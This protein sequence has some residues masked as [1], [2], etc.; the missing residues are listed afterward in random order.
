M[1]VPVAAVGNR[2][3]GF[4]R[5]GG[6]V[7]GVHGSGSFHGPFPIF[8]RAR[9]ETTAQEAPGT[10]IDSRHDPD[11]PLLARPPP[12]LSTCGQ[13]V[14]AHPGSSRLASNDVVPFIDLSQ[15]DVTEMN[16]PDAVV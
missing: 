5:S 11:Y 6:R 3:A 1:R 4:P 8:G 9:G 2:S 15:Q 10:T 12:T 13:P 7:L 16:R 14:A